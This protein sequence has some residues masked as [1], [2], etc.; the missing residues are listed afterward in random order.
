VTGL[1]AT[2]AGTTGLG[3]TCAGAAGLEAAGAGAAG[4]RVVVLR[5]ALGFALA[6]FLGAT[7]FGAGLRATALRATLGAEVFFL[8]FAVLFALGFFLVAIR[9]LPVC[10]NANGWLT[11]RQAHSAIHVPTISF[12]QK[13][14][15]CKSPSGVRLTFCR[16]R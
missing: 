9:L 10:I 13:Y 3:A 4:L 8:V 5:A 12:K 2:G 11:N 14:S 6:L 1:G 15:G 16:V 7:F